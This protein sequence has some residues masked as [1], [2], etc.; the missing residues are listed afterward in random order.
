MTR[1]VMT[2]ASPSSATSA[3][4]WPRLRRGPDQPARPPACGG[5]RRDLMRIDAGPA[6]AADEPW[7]GPSGAADDRPDGAE[8]GD[9]APRRP[10]TVDAVEPVRG[11]G[12]D[13]PARRTPSMP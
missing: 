12:S 1:S 4:R 9:L 11:R 5:T 6:C 13:E 3:G 7:C 8:S 2:P 10:A